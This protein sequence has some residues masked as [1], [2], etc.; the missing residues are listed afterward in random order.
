MLNSDVSSLNEL[1]SS[2]LLFT[3]HLG[4][5]IS[6]N[7][8]LNA[9][10]SKVF[11]FNSLKLSDFKILV[12]DNSAIVSVKAEIKGNY[13]GQPA[14]GNFRFTRFWSNMSGKWQVI[15][16]HSSVIA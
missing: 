1:I 14:N 10:S 12:Q 5:L 13:N 16:G 3:N 8:D 9:H 15:A 2:E 7:E 6:K 4:V 11:V